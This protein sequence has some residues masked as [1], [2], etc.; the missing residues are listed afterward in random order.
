MS[1]EIGSPVPHSLKFNEECLVISEALS[2][3]P[4]ID[5]KSNTID[6]HNVAP[7]V[8]DATA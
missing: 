1:M 2:L 6:G 7:R 3:R 8:D 4:S 5:R